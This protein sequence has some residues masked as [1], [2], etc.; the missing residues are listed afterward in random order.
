MIASWVRTNPLPRFS[1]KHPQKGSDDMGQS[2]YIPLE[3]FL[4]DQQINLTVPRKEVYLLADEEFEPTANALSS[5]ENEIKEYRR[6]HNCSLP[7]ALSKVSDGN[8]MNIYE[9]ITGCRLE[10]IDD[11]YAVQL[12]KYGRVCSECLKPL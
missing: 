6:K 12:S 4:Y 9:R 11:L 7:R 10:R 3:T 2:W 8:A 5:R 1:V